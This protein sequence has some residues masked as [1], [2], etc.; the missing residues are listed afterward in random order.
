VSQ[1]VWTAVLAPILVGV[2]LLVFRRLGTTVRN[3]AAV[4]VSA[5]SLGT[6]VA[7]WRLTG[8]LGR[9]FNVGPLFA[10]D[11]I[12]LLLA[13][14]FGLIWLLVTL[15]S[16]FYMVP[17]GHHDDYYGFLL[18]MLGS[19]VAFCFGRNLVV[20]YTAWE[21]AGLT[22]WRLVAFYRRDAE[23]AIAGRTLLITFTGSVLM[24]VGLA[25]VYLDYGALETTALAGARLDTLP[26]VLLLAGMVTKSASLPLYVWLP[27]AHT[28]APSPMSAL[29]SG[30]V[31]KL[32]LV[33]Y[34]KLFLQSGVILPD[35][36]M[37][38]VAGL[39]LAG[40]L[41]AGGCALRE[42]DIKRVLAF[43]TVSQLGYIFIGFALATSIGLAAGVIYLVAHAL[44]KAGLFMALG[45]VEHSTHERDIRQL[46]GLAQGMPVTA[47]A[48][49]LL[50]LSIIGLPP[51]FGFFGKFYVLVAAVP[52][53][54]LVA[55]GAAVAAVLTLLY[56]VRLYRIFVGETGSGAAGHESWLMT[57]C[58]F[59]LALVSTGLGV[60]FPFL[61]DTVGRGL[62]F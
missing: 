32:G 39:G 45:I 23:V 61:A 1:L 36:W 62:G 52:Q 48:T 33:A 9:M 44:A 6:V 40:A 51:L 26:A 21:I 20:L 43:S 58:V 19:I 31:A 27:D 38:L 46:R 42:N 12:G 24:L 56:M 18:I 49:A 29:L 22:T 13:T 8:G 7:L 59:L 60:A 28:A 14:V 17:H 5:I 2:V 50:M 11:N 54:L 16:L 30:I 4:L 25:L 15:Y 41:V 55:A 37:W 3:V 47:A 10:L 53:S 57:A 35:W 34:V